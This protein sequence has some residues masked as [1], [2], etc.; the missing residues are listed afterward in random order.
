[1]KTIKILR[2]FFLFN[3]VYLMILGQW[4]NAVVVGSVIVLSFAPDVL[5]WMTGIELTSLMKAFFFLFLILSQWCGTYLRAYEFISWWDIFLHGLSAVL[6]G[7]GAFIVLNLCDRDFLSFEYERYGLI[8]TLIFLTISSSAVFWEIFE[9]LGDTLLGTNAQL[10]SLKDTMGDMLICVVIGALIS[11]WSYRSLKSK[12]NN[13][14][15]KQLQ[16]FILLNKD[17]EK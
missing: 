8:S 10:G 13:F 6:V 2:I 7:L 16:A 15:T 11:L 12:K 17:R 5:R 1:M 4:E 14:M 3:I 9:F